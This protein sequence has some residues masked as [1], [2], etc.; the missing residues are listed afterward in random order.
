VLNDFPDTNPPMNYL[1]DLIPF[2]KHRYFSI[3][4]LLKN[5]IHMYL[6]YFTHFYPNRYVAIVEFQTP[7]KRIRNGL[8]TQYLSTLKENEIISNVEIKKGSMKLPKNNDPIVRE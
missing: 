3:A 2:I 7:Y 8:C 4:S 1:F 5:E 6:I